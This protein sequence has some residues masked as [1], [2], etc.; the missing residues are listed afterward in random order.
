MRKSFVGAWTAGLVVIAGLA[1][2]QPALAQQQYVGTWGCEFTYTEMNQFG[3]RTSGHTRQYLIAIYPNGSF[4]AQGQ[5]G[6]A[7]GYQPF[8]SQGQWQVDEQSGKLMAQGQ[9][10]IGGMPSP[11][12]FVMMG[13]VD[14]DGAFRNAYEQV[15]PSNSYVMNRQLYFCQRQ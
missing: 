4:E 15:D 9:E 5:M 14:P 12:A 2:V 7:M 11:G 10:Y 13:G 6:S 1:G 3:Q 8:Q